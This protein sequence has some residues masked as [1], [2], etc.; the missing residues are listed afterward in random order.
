[1]FRVRVLISFEKFSEK[2]VR[3]IWWIRGEC[4]PL[5][6]LSERKRR[7][8]SGSGVIPQGLQRQKV[9][10]SSPAVKIFF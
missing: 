5:H 4:V 2:S 8:G 3:K 9:M 1:M 7:R 6:P 10:E